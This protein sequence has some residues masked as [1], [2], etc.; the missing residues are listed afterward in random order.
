MHSHFTDTWAIERTGAHPSTVRRWRRERRLPP[1]LVRLAELEID[2]RI[3]HIHGR[4]S[5]WIIDTRSGEL[6][7]P[8]GDRFTAGEIQALP[9]TLQ[10]LSELKRRDNGRRKALKD[11]T[12]PLRA[13]ILKAIRRLLRRPTGA[14][15]EQSFAS[16]SAHPSGRRH[17]PR[18]NPS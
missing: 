11:R 18:R 1:A 3:E 17:A 7:S 14:G 5:G 2:G 12:R 16:P 10:L 4:W 9:I 13:R 6:V 8:G 15:G